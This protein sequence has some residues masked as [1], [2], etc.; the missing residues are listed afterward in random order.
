MKAVGRSFILCKQRR[1][2]YRSTDNQL[3]H[4]YGEKDRLPVAVHP[5]MLRQACGLAHADQDADTRLI[6]EYQ[7]NCNI[8]HA[9]HYT[10][11][12]RTSSR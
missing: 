11:T 12:R 7:G 5:Q 3:L 8:Q 9:A 2:L 6:Q 10:D 1:A 4:K